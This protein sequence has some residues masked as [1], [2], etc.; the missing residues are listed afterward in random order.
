MLRLFLIPSFPDKFLQPSFFNAASLSLS[1]FSPL[2]VGSVGY[3]ASVVF[4]GPFIYL[5]VHLLTD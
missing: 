1:F 2:A 5:S 4:F 3:S